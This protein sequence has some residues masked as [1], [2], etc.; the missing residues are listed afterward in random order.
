MNALLVTNQING[1]RVNI[2]FETDVIPRI[3]ETISNDD[4][5]SLSDEEGH[6]ISK[7][8]VTEVRHHIMSSCNGNMAKCYQVT[9]F[10]EPKP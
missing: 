8:N 2:P 3:G 5:P 10:I 9:I 7:W 1:F 6:R 4:I